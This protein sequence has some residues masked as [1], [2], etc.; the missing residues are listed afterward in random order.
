[1]IDHQKKFIFIHIPK[2]AGV[3]MYQAFSAKN[4]DQHHLTLKEHNHTDVDYF[5]FAFVRNP[6]DRFV[7][8]YFYF[9]NYGRSR[10]GDKPSGEIV[11]SF[12]DFHEFC[13]NFENVLDKFPLPHFKKMSSWF[14]ENLSFVGK[15]ENLQN[16]FNYV[17][18][19]ISIKPQALPKLNQT[20]RQHYSHYYN[21]ESKSIIESFYQED[22]IKFGYSFKDESKT[23][24]SL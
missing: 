23:S 4:E 12:S 17:C 24:K 15:F 8:T 10:W 7:S 16:D 18:K 13:K 3:S 1:M 11:N 19:K 2:T 22:I 21:D 14:D 5:S 9:K 20:N 6:W